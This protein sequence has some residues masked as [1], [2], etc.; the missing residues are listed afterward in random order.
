MMG[1]MGCGDKGGGKPEKGA[2][3]GAGAG[4]VTDRGGGGGSG[5]F[6]G[7]VEARFGASLR[8]DR[9]CM[10]R[11][12]GEAALRWVAMFVSASER[13]AIGIGLWVGLCW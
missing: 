1:I 4:A 10:E 8:E 7:G 6:R 2:G 3:A 13:G 9:A 5:V 12:A 11:G